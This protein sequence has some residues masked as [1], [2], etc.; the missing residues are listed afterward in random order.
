MPS[1]ALWVLGVTEQ[2]TGYWAPL[3]VRERMEDRA[4]I[5]P[6]QLTQKENTYAD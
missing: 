3:F 4:W 2:K 6:L 5:G 1:S